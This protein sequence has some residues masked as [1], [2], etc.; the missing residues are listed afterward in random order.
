[1]N[2]EIPFEKFNCDTK[3]GDG[4]IFFFD[5]YLVWKLKGDYS[6]KQN[7]EIRYKDIK[8]AKVYQTRKKTIQIQ[9]KN[10]TVKE[11]YLYKEVEFMRILCA[12]VNGLDAASITPVEEKPAKETKNDDLEKLERLAKLHESGALSDEEFKAAKKKILG[13]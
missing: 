5:E 3:F 2:Y 12:K 11:F 7:I 1:M 8:D 6:E 10:G 4:Q 9:L 13:L